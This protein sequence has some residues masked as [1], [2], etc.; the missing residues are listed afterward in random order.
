MGGKGRSTTAARPTCH[1]DHVTDDRDLFN[2]PVSLMLAKS[3]RDVPGHAALPG[4]GAWEWKYDGYRLC[5]QA[6]PTGG[7]ALWSRNGTNLSETFPDLLEAAQDQ[8]PGGVVLDGEAVV[9]V[10]GG[11]SFDHLQQRMVSR[12]AT[13]AAL[14][15]QHPASYVAFDVL[16]VAGHDVRPL[17]WRDRRAL[18]DELGAGLVAPLQLSPYTTDHQTALRW[19]AEL[20]R[21][22]EGVV[23]KGQAT[24]YRPGQRGWL[25][26]RAYETT[27]AIVGA[28]IGPVSHPEAII[29]GRYTTDGQ[30]RI[31]GRSTPLT[32]RQAQQLAAVLEVVPAAQHPW[33]REIGSGHFG[34][35]PVAITHVNPVLVVEIAADTALQAGRQRHPVRL[36]RLRSDMSP[37]DVPTGL[38]GG[39]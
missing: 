3:A 17:P 29:A 22:V 15:R 13:V 33:P 28:V 8:I 26:T 31:V 35:G 37:M 21:G 14:A 12:R 39:A 19:L 25:K 10:D 24:P 18:L 7:V 1:A 16:A 32:E 36:M 30:L 34:G 23:A 27:D 6:P 11:L 5:V 9:L 38:P 4:G 20:P 2:G